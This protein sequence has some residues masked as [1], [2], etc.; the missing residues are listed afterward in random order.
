VQSRHGSTQSTLQTEL[1]VP[2]DFAFVFDIDG[3]L[4]RSSKN[5]PGAA[6]TL[7]FLHNHSIP[8]ILLTNGGGKHETER[9]AELSATF[10]IPLTIDNFVQSHTPFQEMV[11]G[12]HEYP[13]LE[14]KTILVTGNDQ[15][16]VRDVAHK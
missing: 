7:R 8:F 10:G 5:L 3:V 15:E 12:N 1:S 13:A 4:L 2:P 14:D 16:R 9:V 11:H 6:A